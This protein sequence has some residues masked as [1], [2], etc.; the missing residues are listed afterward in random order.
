VIAKKN[1]TEHCKNRDSPIS[2]NDPQ[3]SKTMS[4]GCPLFK[5]IMSEANT[6]LG[7]KGA[8]VAAYDERMNACFSR[9]SE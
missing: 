2:P 6:L 3:A 5:I 1:E 9:L 7:F 8:G 4:G